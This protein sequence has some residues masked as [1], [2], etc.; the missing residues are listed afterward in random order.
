V[1][2]Y[3]ATAVSSHELEDRLIEELTGQGFHLSFRAVTP[4]DLENYLSVFDHKE[5]TLLICD[6]TFK[7]IVRKERVKTDSQLAYLFIN[8]RDTWS[9]GEVTRSAH[10]A[11]RQPLVVNSHSPR[12]KPRGDWFGVVGTSGSPGIST[13]T[14]NMAAELSQNLPVR[15][16]D[17][18]N[19]NKD[20]HI[21]LGARREGSSALTS[22]L[23]LMTV[24]NDADRQHLEENESVMSFIDIGE[25]P[26]FHSEMLTDRRT[27]MRNSINLITRSHHLIYVLQPENR[28]L[29]EVDSFLNFAEQELDQ[30][31]ITFLLNKMGNATRHKGILRSLKNRISD[32]A[33]FV[34]PR[35]YALFDRAQARYAT[36][37][38]V[39]ARTSARRAISELSIYLS[40]SI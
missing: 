6:E 8:S 37:A 33:L 26:K 35:D 28:A 11:L 5:R 2:I 40:K 3:F 15:I 10:E 4:P 1:K 39:G 19:R 7:V 16:V 25:T 20:L 12:S 17:A 13:M 24:A 30:T 9:E 32:H 36:L 38:E 29:V 14:I 27:S 21:L 22:N 34:V 23:S 31:Q 18:D